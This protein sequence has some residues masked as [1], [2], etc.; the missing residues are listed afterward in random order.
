[1]SNKYEK[2]H[3]YYKST[4]EKLISRLLIK[5]EDDGENGED[6]LNQHHDA[7]LAANRNQLLDKVKKEL[8]HRGQYQEVDQKC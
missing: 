6:A 2:N 3:Q 5:E 8:L 4:L 7:N 1:M